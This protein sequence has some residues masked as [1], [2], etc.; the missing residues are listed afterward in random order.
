MSSTVL[1]KFY[2]SH[3]DESEFTEKDFAEIC[4]EYQE[5]QYVKTSLNMF[6]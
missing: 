4:K 2:S 3:H 5:N 6:F 1:K